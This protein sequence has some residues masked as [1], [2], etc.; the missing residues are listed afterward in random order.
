[1]EI[2]SLA[3]LTEPDERSLRFTPLGLSTSGVMRPA[4]AAQHIQHTV[5]VDLAGSV[6]DSVRRSFEHVLRAHVYGLFCYELF[7][8]AG[9]QSL[10]VLEQALAERFVAYYQGTIPLVDAKGHKSRL[11]V[12]TFDDVYD[13]LNKSSGSHA[14]GQWFVESLVE[15][16][17]QLE[18]PFKGSFSHLFAWA[19]YERLLDGQRSRAHDRILIKIRNAAAHPTSYRLLMP[20]DSARR[21]RDIAEIINRLWGHRTP[22]GRIFPAPT[23]R[24]IFAIGWDPYG[25]SVFRSWADQLET[26]SEHCGWPHLIVRALPIDELWSYDADF[27]TTRYPVDLLWGPGTWSD[28]IAWLSQ[29]RPMTDDIDY[30]DRWFVVRTQGVSNVDPPRSPNQFAGLGPA[31]QGGNWYLLQADFPED[32]FACARWVAGS[33]AGA[34]TGPAEWVDVKAVGDWKAVFAEA[35]RLGLVTTPV[36]PVGARVPFNFG[37]WR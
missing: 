10:L 7:T 27:Q 9:E 16:G 2:R 33:S 5:A 24:E 26:E 36:P 6:S 1:M 23:Q 37:Y 31:D 3:Q 22:G 15:P 25:A 20:T 32:A 12:R 30:L 18:R 21:I 8:V 14:K 4:A 13:A 11:R 29:S 17:G 19:R 35:S 28:A 34:T